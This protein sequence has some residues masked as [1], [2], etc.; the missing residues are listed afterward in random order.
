MDDKSILEY[1]SQVT[2]INDTSAYMEDKQLDEA[3]A[4]VIKIMMKPDL[5]SVVIPDLI[6]QLEAMA[7][8]FSIK[9]TYYA[10]IDRGK[11]GTEQSNKKNIYYS[12]SESL[13]RVCDGLKYKCRSNG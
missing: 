9:K 3:M 13:T 5:P 4:I 12:V 11:V 6:V 7:A 10:T 1:I 8:V 2:E